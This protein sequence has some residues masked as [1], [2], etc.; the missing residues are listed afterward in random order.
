[1]RIGRA[2]RA[3]WA[4]VAVAAGVAAGAW[5]V[6]CCG[7]WALGLELAARGWPAL[8]ELRLVPALL[9]VAF[10]ATALTLTVTSL[11]RQSLATV[12]LDRSMKRRKLPAPPRLVAASDAA[13]LRP[14]AKLVELA[15]P[16]SCT[17]GVLRPQV[18]ISRGLLERVDDT[19]LVAVLAHEA[20]HVRAHDP[21]KVVLARALRQ[22]LFVLPALGALYDRYLT[23]RELAADRRASRRV[24]VQG[25][26]GALLKATGGP[27][28]LDVGAA[29]ALGGDRALDLRVAQLETGQAPPLAPLEQ[30]CLGISATAALAIGA[31]MASAAI[32]LG[33][34]VS[35]IC[36]CP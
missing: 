6:L 18:V 9:L 34:L 4:I 3:F 21:L 23:A 7:A 12:R 13:E 32:G 27:T 16:F 2:D 35:R 28:E 20:Q 30:R 5:A 29:A 19:E 31:V 14:E 33:P 36:H 10:L 25:L 8:G 1:M 17:Y 24:G 15:A 11:V 26:A 22:G